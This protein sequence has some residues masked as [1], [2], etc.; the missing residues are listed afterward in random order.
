VEGWI[1]TRSHFYLVETFSKDHV[2][3]SEIQLPLSWE[4]AKSILDQLVSVV[5]DGLHKAAKVV[6]RDLKAEN[7]LCNR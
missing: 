3:L 4:M 1:K 2:P 6:H 5:R 7:V